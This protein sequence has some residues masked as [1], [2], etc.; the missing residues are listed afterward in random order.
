MS[1]MDYMDLDLPRS[2]S[3]GGRQRMIHEAHRLL[4]SDTLAPEAAARLQAAVAQWD[5]AR[6]AYAGLHSSFNETPERSRI[7]VAWHREAPKALLRAMQLTPG[8]PQY[9]A[10]Q[11]MLQRKRKQ[12]SAHVC[13]ACGV[14]FTTRRRDAKTCSTNCRQAS[15]RLAAKLKAA[16]GGDAE[17]AAMLGS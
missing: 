13:A 14:S 15:H 12:P 1:S 17:L 3:S 7:W 11:A 6:E 10:H 4:G 16:A 2:R 5:A 9:V 8:A